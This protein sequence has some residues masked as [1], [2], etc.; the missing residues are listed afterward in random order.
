MLRDRRKKE[1]KQKKYQDDFQALTKKK[2]T[3]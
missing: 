3:I 1:R 2:N